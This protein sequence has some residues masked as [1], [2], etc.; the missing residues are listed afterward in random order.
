MKGHGHHCTCPPHSLNLRDEIQK[1]CRYQQCMEFR[2]TGCN[3]YLGGWGAIGC[4]CTGD[5]RWL[6]H[7]GMAHATFRWRLSGDGHVPVKPS[8]A[9]RDQR[10]THTRTITRR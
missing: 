3:A 5:W 7:T 8:K 1:M 9:R 2:C 6:R 4:K 10:G